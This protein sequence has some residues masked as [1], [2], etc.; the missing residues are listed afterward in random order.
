M[1]DTGVRQG[2][3]VDVVWIVG[4]VVET[5]EKEDPNKATR[6]FYTARIF[7][8]SLCLPHN[9]P[10]RITDT[11]FNEWGAIRLPLFAY[12][13]CKGTERESKRPTPTVELTKKYNKN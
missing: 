10:T 4:V 12:V 3:A 5:E 7:P 11:V 1:G 13:C 9:N 2:N 6:E 8:V